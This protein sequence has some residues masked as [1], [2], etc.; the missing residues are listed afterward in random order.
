MPLNVQPQARKSP[1][2]LFVSPHSLHR[3]TG[4]SEVR[5]VQ[6]ARALRALGEVST[7]VVDSEGWAQEWETLPNPEFTLA[8]R[9][10]VQNFPNGTPL[11]KLRWMYGARLNYPHGVGVAA[12][13]LTKLEAMAQQHDLLWFCKLRIAN[14]FPRWSWPRSVIDVDDVPS[15]HAESELQ[16]ARGFR[17]KAQAWL[18]YQSWRR[19]DCL[20]GERSDVLGVCSE[21]DRE[22]LRDLGV[23]K[24]VHVI[25]N[26]FEMPTVEPSRNPANPPRFG[27]VGIFDYA[28]NAE[29]AH[30][31]ARE[32]WPRIKQQLPDAQLRL[33]GRLSD[34][35]LKPA[36]PDID[37]LGFVPDATAEMAT[38]TAMIVPI[39]TGAGTRGKIA[40]A[41]SAKCPVV[42]TTLG[43][44]G[45]G[46]VSG[47]D[48]LLADSP[49]DFAAGCIRVVREPGLGRVLAQTAWQQFLEK[50]TWD[51]IQ[52][53]VHAAVEDCLRINARPR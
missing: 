43:A 34:G 32:C 40:H 30:W 4:A 39:L 2:I 8:H 3:M 47:K 28:P 16:N 51:A 5:A 50:W 29:G 48:A 22:Y 24:P 35:P 46:L 44:H 45:Y 13:G 9:F 7:V 17:A 10:G 26:G 38:W 25:P 15:T 14:Q 19:R 52:P 31:F 42:S 1:R 6:T 23:R 36:G 53:K 37:G 12:A 41:F 11:E 21:P 33:M 18:R 27:F 20:L 49:E